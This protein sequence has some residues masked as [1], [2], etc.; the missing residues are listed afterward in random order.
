MKTSSAVLVAAVLLVAPVAHAQEWQAP[1][2]GVVKEKHV[3][4]LVTYYKA[5]KKVNGTWHGQTR[6]SLSDIEKKALNEAS[7]DRLEIEWLKPRVLYIARNLAL[8]AATPEQLEKAEKKSTERLSAIKRKI[9][10]LMKNGPKELGEL[11][12]IE[13]E[14]VRITREEADA[15]VGA[16]IVRI[17]LTAAQQRASDALAAGDQDKQKKSQAEVEV[18]TTEKNKFE[19][20]TI[21]LARKSDK[22]RQRQLEVTEKLQKVGATDGLKQVALANETRRDLEEIQAA[23]KEK[24]ANTK[25]D[26]VFDPSVAA[27]KA[28]LVDLEKALAALGSPFFEAVA[29]K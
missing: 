19:D 7:V 3:E 1:E 10:D 20:T 15:F 9:D 2:D 25:V 11:D 6:S 24:A 26:A 29:P 17:K 12:E 28:K 4:D 8:Q 18:L 22:I 23:K 21:A 27:V 5:L 13:A 14:L 16:M